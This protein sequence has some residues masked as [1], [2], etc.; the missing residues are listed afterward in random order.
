[1]DEVALLPAM[2]Q[3][4]TP[5]PR[6]ASAYPDTDAPLTL[7]A[8]QFLRRRPDYRKRW[9]QLQS[10]GLASRR[11]AEQKRLTE[12][13][14]A[15]SSA[16]RLC[17]NLLSNVQ[18]WIRDG[19]PGNTTM[20]AIE[21]PTPKLQKSETVPAAIDRLRQQAA[22]L[23]TKLAEIEKAPLPSAL[24]RAKMRE[25]LG[26]IAERG[27]IDVSGLFRPAAGQLGFPETQLM[28][29]VFNSEPAAA[30]IGALP[31]IVGLLVATNLE[32]VTALSDKKIAAEARDD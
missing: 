28:L 29:K 20:Q 21:V 2:S 27:A 11:R 22:S 18:A 14:A 25:Q 26:R 1:M 32:A 4:G 30:A 12:L 3:W 16:W 6:N 5:D 7:Y 23:R 10:G 8:W 19:R 15:R 13:D 9:T 24:A 31:D 17:G